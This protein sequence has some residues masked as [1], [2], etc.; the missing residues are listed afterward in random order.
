MKITYEKRSLFD[1]PKG[2]YLVHACNAQGVW[3][4]GIATM[5]RRKFP[6]AH[7][8]YNKLCRAEPDVTLGMAFVI[9]DN[10][11]GVVCL[12]VSEGYGQYKSPKEDILLY[13]KHALDQFLRNIPEGSN[14]YSNKFN[15]GFFKVPWP[16][17]EK[18][19]QEALNSYKVNWTVCDP[20]LT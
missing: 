10:D 16:E 12:I 3:G 5:F 6:H 7:D 17:T 11:Y 1:T 20:E 8:E 4:S 14:V 19:L 2:S 15:S 13:T 9:P 18:I